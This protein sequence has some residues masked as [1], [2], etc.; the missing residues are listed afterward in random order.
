MKGVV[1]EGL[2]LAKENEK[3]NILDFSSGDRNDFM[4]I[5]QNAGT[6]SGKH[7]HNGIEK[8]KNP[9]ITLV[10]SGKFELFCRDIKTQE[11]EK[12]LVTENTK[13]SIY[14]EIYHEVRA[15]SDIILLEY[16]SMAQAKNDTVKL[17]NK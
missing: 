4:L 10:I 2:S 1:I 6:V 9:E 8:N 12:F 16:V 5:K 7:Y 14:P 13:I 3:M 17:K 15:I 11:E